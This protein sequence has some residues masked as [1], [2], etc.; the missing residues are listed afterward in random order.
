MKSNF[1]NK[2][3]V[4][5]IS[6]MFFGYHQV[7]NDKLQDLGA[8]VHYYDEKPSNNALFKGA[9]R[10]NRNVLPRYID[11]YYQ[12][13]LKKIENESY[14][15]LFV[16]KGEVITEDFIQGFKKS[17]PKAKCF[18]MLWDSIKNYN[19]VLDKVELFNRTFSFDKDDCE[20][21]GFE[22]RPLFF[23]EKYLTIA[24]DHDNLLYDIS[25]IGTVHSDRLK[26]LE[27]IKRKLGHSYSYFYY[28]YIP[29][30][31]LFYIKKIFKK[32]FRVKPKSYFQFQGLSGD[33]VL[34]KISQS[35][36]VIDI[37]HPK[38]TG[39][40]MRT[41]EM[42]GAGRKIITTNKS[43]KEYDFYC[44]E[45]IFIIDR[46]NIKIDNDFLTCEFKKIDKGILDYYS[47]TGFLNQ[48]FKD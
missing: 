32:E 44:K 45:N 40:T 9:M 37:E 15:F 2:K 19:Y 20:Q 8:I 27:E 11:S 26:I 3:K 6:P 41:I 28:L 35:R 36:I 29:S 7:I 38:Q 12:S 13:I 16:V 42:L 31:L 1:L 18:L 5:F 46:N 43:V 34:K 48:I 23:N 47:V 24:H 21:Y 39:L 10:L 30:K 4:L 17:N 14:D 22:F 33:K 25:F